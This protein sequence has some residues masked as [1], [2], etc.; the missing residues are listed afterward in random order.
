MSAI[1]PNWLGSVAQTQGAQAH[2]ATQ[3]NREA[4]A[5]A[6]RADASFAER[7]TS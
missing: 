7:L 6:E 2:S 5:A 1:P 3:K 4:G